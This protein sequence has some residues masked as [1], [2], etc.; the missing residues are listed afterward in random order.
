MILEHELMRLR[1]LAW[2]LIGISNKG[3]EEIGKIAHLN[4]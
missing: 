4:Y 3:M 2:T 1:V